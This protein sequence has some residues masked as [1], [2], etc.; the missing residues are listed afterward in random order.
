MEIKTQE[1]LEGVLRKGETIL[2]YEYYIF[3]LIVTLLI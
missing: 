3:I 2:C 1:S